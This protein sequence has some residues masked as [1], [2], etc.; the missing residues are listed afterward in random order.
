MSVLGII[1]ATLLGVTDRHRAAVEQ[2]A[3]AHH[4]WRV[5][6]DLSQYAAAGAADLLVYVA[7]ILKLP[8]VRDA[9]AST[10]WSLASNRG[11]AVAWPAPVR[12]LRAWQPWLMGWPDRASLRVSG[13]SLAADA[14][15]RPGSMLPLG[16]A[17]FWRVTCV[18]RRAGRCGLT[19]GHSPVLIDQPSCSGFNLRGGATLTP[20]FFAL[21]LGLTIYTAAFIAEIVR[22]GIQSVSQGPARGGAGAGADARSDPAAGDLS[23]GAARD[24]PAADQPVSEPDQELEPGHSPSATSICS[25]SRIRSR[26]RAARTVQ[27]IVILMGCYLSAEPGNVAAHESV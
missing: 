17:C 21:L 13:P 11:L 26:T 5:C 20:E 19:S 24:H 22:G 23:A 25:T 4:R 1:L 10:A 12:D 8:R 6:R 14:A 9:S 7:V 2:L 16:A 3:A 15:D 18:R 27:V